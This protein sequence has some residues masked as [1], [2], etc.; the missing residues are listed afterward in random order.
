MHVLTENSGCPLLGFFLFALSAG[1]ASIRAWCSVGA[2]PRVL[3]VDDLG[4]DH[5]VVGL[6]LGDG[7]A[8][9]ATALEVGVLLFLRGHAGVAGWECRE[10]RGLGGELA[11]GHADL[12]EFEEGVLVEDGAGAGGEVDAEHGAVL[13]L[14]LELLA[15]GADY[16]GGVD[17]GSS[18]AADDDFADCGVLFGRP[19]HDALEFVPFLA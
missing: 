8:L 6:V 12:G 17:D 7:C 18:V 4:F 5:L 13:G 14:D 2:E 3:L 9:G 19:V 11:L 10:R 16:G 15:D 1:R